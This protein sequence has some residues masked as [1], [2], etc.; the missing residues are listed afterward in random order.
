[1]ISRSRE[2]CVCHDLTIEN[3]KRLCVHYDLTIENVNSVFVYLT[4][5]VCVC[6]A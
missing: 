1:M 4:T 3:V 2:Q 5:S 6:V